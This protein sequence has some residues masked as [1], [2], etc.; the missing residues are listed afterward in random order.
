MP[1]APPETFLPSFMFHWFWVMSAV[2]NTLKPKRNM[3]VRTDDCLG[4]AQKV[5]LSNWINVHQP[6]HEYYIFTITSFE[7]S[8]VKKQLST[9]Q[10]KKKK[11]WLPFFFLSQDV[12]FYPTPAQ[13]ISILKYNV[14]Q[15]FSIISEIQW[16]LDESFNQIFSAKKNSRPSN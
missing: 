10:R 3:H 9:H 12:D 4:T 7:L 13:K 8:N 11:V 2:P 5:Q 1:L 6:Q 16:P 14:L 15:D